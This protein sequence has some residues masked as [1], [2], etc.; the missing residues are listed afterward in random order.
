MTATAHQAL[1]QADE[2]L[3][4][5]DAVE[6]RLEELLPPAAEQDLVGI[7]VREGVLAPGKRLRPLLLLLT[8]RDLGCEL[9]SI[10]DLACAVEMVHAASLV[11]DD[12]PCMDNARMRRGRP[13]VH[14][15]FGEDVAILAAVALLSRAFGVIA[16]A[17]AHA[18]ACAAE[19]VGQMATAVGTQGLVAGQYQDLREG[20][21]A[22]SA[23]AIVQTNAL[24]T[25]VLFSA[26]VQ[27]AAVAA[28]AVP[29]VRESLAHF[30]LELGQAFQLLDDLADGHTHTGKDCH[31]DAGKTTLV[32]LLGADTVHQ[33]L[34]AH[35]RSADRHLA[36]ACGDGMGT[37][38]FMQAWFEQQLATLAVQRPAPR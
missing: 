2:L 6:R 15:Q 17:S 31:Q 30:A 12:M 21:R 7:A 28:G 26:T 24:K 8:A 33:R 5:R 3:A 34:R 23:E 36:C 11:L 32:A 13:T 25:G 27:M 37:R 9:A 16:A 14:C 22:R 38:R 4:L 20:A 10:V 35:L 19:L 1:E 29:A 18:P